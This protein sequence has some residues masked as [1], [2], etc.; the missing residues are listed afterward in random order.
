MGSASRQYTDE[1]V[2]EP[3]TLRIYTGANGAYTLYEDDGISMAYLQGNFRLTEMNWDDHVKKL[4][5][6]PGNSKNLQ[7]GKRIFKVELIP[8]GITKANNLY[9]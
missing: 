4:I 8:Q 7:T 2:N 6:T 1:P 9:G 3:T 5:L